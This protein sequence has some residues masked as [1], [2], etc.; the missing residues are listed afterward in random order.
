MEKNDNITEE[1]N[2]Q[3]VE[4]KIEQSEA[5]E[6]TPEVAEEAPEVVA[7][8]ATEV[9]A[10]EATEAV[11]E[12]APE[13]VTEEAPEVVSEKADKKKKKS[14]E[15]DE[16]DFGKML[17]KSY[18]A[19]FEMIAGDWVSGP[20]VKITD[21]T[22]FVSLGDKLD[23]H[24]D[25]N[26]YKK[27]GEEISL[28]EGDE[29]GGYIV[30]LTDS[31]I[32]L[33]KHMTKSSAPDKSAIRN[34]YENKI[35]VSGKVQRIIKG[36]YEIDI[37]G[38]R[39]F[40]PY[41]HMSLRP[42]GNKEQFLGQTYDF[43]LI[44]FTEKGRNIVVSRK[45]LMEKESEKRKQEIMERLEPGMVLEGKVTRL[46]DFG[47]FV[48]LGGMEGLV[49]VSEISWARV[50]H[51]KDVLQEGQQVTV[52]ILKL[53]PNA[54]KISLSM[55]RTEMNPLDKAMQELQEEQ[56]VKCLIVKNE[57]F[58]S[59]VEISPG[60]QGLIPISEMK[61]G[62]R[63]NHPSEVV[64]IGDEVEALIMRINRE[65]KKI[66]LSM[67]ALEPDPWDSIDQ[68]L[69]EEMIIEGEIDG[70]A[71][72]GVFVKLRE[73]LT[74]LIPQSKLRIAKK[75]YHPDNVG[76]KVSVR[77]SEIDHSK[78]RISLEPSDMPSVQLR[79]REDSNWRRYA[80]QN[81]SQQETDDN[82]FS[83]L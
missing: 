63:I 76:D 80:K 55:K 62:R 17:E 6:K 37:L 56:V 27:E 10:E 3:N 75:E 78:K 66:S 16:D 28:K 34:A 77:V 72:F 40:C 33:S 82:P 59:F 13:V 32:I 30:K 39:A 15:S 47:A 52:K 58:G 2:E 54:E 51:P 69:Q 73:G 26:E 7:E 1:M 45:V 57:N 48:D 11:T 24:A 36:G 29:L 14:T 44:D 60:V 20:I 35:P 68:F 65:D 70:I 79:P 71:E 8:E 46:I 19:A 64:K 81:W 38:S 22:I 5:V 23:A 31:E 43:Q 74:G 53:K 42:S 50:N 49:H 12:E 4:K 18:A 61:K 9:V 67:K 21:D 83:K 25:L 41:T